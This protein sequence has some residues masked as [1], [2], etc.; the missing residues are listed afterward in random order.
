VANLGLERGA[1]TLVLKSWYR[2][3]ESRENDDNRD[4][5]DYLGPGEIQAYYR[6]HEHR[7]GM[8]LRNNFHRD[9]NRSSVLFDW[10]FPV[11]EK[12]GIYIQYFNG[13]GENLLDYDQYA[14]RI[15]I[16]FI[17]SDWK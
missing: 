2:I 15:G 17:L 7:F 13:Y 16:G 11:M 14:N 1:F 5:D 8:M 9:N 12:V 10:S 4:I 6:W 3:S